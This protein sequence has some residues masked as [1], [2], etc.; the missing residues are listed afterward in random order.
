MVYS[1]SC[2]LCFRGRHLFWE[3]GDG[4]GIRGGSLV[5][6]DPECC[7]YGTLERYDG[8]YGSGSK[9]PWGSHIDIPHGDHYNHDT[10]LYVECDSGSDV[11]LPLGR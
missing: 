9:C 3:S 8:L 5:D 2:R 10:D 6:T 1:F 7:R 11:V 4:V